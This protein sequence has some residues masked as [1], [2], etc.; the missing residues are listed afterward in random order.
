MSNNINLLAKTLDYSSLQQKVIGKNIANVTTVGYQRE[1]VSFRNELQNASG[2]KL[3][4][5]NSR[6][7]MNGEEVLGEGSDL[8]VTQDKSKEMVSGFNNVDIDQEMANLAKN[9]IMFRFASKRLNGIFQDLQMVIR[10]G[11]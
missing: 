11:R 7:I 4:V 10:G 3:K 8:I 5:T 2:N 6:H 1:E 9:N